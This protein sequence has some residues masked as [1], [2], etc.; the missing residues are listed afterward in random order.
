MKRRFY[1]VV[2]IL[3]LPL[4]CFSEDS[5]HIVEKNK[6]QLKDASYTRMSGHIAV[7]AVQYK[8]YA[9]VPR[10]AIFDYAFGATFE[11]YKKLN[12]HGVLI[13]RNSP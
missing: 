8:K 13:E 6:T 1:L 9:P 2:I 12:S 4:F 5:A 10:V 11:E 7:A 3:A